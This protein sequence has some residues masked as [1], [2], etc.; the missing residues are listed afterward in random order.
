MSSNHCEFK[1]NGSQELNF[2]I[3][4]IC[5]YLD[6]DN[7]H[8]LINNIKNTVELTSLSDYFIFHQFYVFGVDTLYNITLGLVNT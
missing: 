2:P 6:M 7:K 1:G 4:S 5:A 8:E 3:D